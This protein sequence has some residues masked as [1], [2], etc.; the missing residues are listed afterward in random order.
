LQLLTSTDHAVIF[1]HT[2]SDAIVTTMCKIAAHKA[3]HVPLSTEPVSDEIDARVNAGTGNNPAGS[4]TGVSSL[5]SVPSLSNIKL[6]LL[7]STQV[8][9]KMYLQQLCQDI[10]F[11]YR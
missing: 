1:R 2:D 8:T 11:L 5:I 3:L 7:G 4:S 10:L 9:S 6:P